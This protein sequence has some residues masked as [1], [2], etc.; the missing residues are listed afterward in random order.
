[1]GKQ[2][3]YSCDWCGENLDPYLNNGGK[4]QILF[5]P[6]GVPDNVIDL[7][8]VLILCRKHLSEFENFIDENY[9]K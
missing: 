6:M 8:S 9:R 4:I 7:K 2:V 5:G 3:I 1:V